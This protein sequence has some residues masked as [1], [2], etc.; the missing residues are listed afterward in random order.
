MG[1]CS[2]LTDESQNLR[3]GYSGYLYQCAFSFVIDD[4]AL[5]NK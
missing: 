3:K 5:G 1:Y 4:P 2:W